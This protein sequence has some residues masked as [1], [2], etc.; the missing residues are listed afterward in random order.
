MAFE[1]KIPEKGDVKGFF[2]LTLARGFH[3]HPINELYKRKYQQAERLTIKEKESNEY[4]FDDN[5]EKFNKRIWKISSDAREELKKVN[6]ISE[7]VKIKKKYLD[8]L[9]KEK[10]KI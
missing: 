1:V 2:K 6:T 3:W 9:K 7:M 5:F 8:K 10:F 4:W